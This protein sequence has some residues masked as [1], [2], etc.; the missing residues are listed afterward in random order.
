MRALILMV[1]SVLAAF[2]TLGLVAG[3]PP[4]R[5]AIPRTIQV[6]PECAGCDVVP[7]IRG[8]GGVSIDGS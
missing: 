4:A 5:V 2:L 6:E 7:F 3:T 8:G 1:L